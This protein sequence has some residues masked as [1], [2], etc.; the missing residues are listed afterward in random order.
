MKF[1][2]L[3]TRVRD[4]YSSNKYQYLDELLDKTFVTDYFLDRSVAVASVASVA[5]TASATKP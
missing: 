2:I 1:A 3:D 4:K 5:A